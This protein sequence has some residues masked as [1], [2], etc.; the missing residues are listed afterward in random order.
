MSMGAQSKYARVMAIP[1]QMPLVLAKRAAYQRRSSRRDV[2][3]KT[4]DFNGTNAP[5]A[6]TAEND[7]A[8]AGTPFAPVAGSTGGCLNQIPVGSS[9][10]QR[11]G[12]KATMTA[13]H[14]RG[15]CFANTATTFS[16]GTML[17]IWQRNP[18]QAAALPAW[19]DILNIQN[20]NSLTNLTNASKFKILRR[21]DFNVTGNQT[22]AQITDQGHQYFDEYIRL[23]KNMVTTW[24]QA[25][26]SGIYTDMV[27][28][29]LLLYFTSSS[30]D[31]T[32]CPIFNIQARVY[33]K[34]I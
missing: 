30:A 1:K 15:R 29:A 28:G 21:W 31:G 25:N 12:K 8:P 13:V 11:I 34:D 20:S 9:V 10:N 14:L 3:H 2:E 4:F 26:T 32:I 18:N 19:A 7:V 33:F 16:Q 5:V 27:E 6:I 24:T 22:A 17:L 23:P